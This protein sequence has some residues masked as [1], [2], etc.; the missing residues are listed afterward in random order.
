MLTCHEINEIKSLQEELRQNQLQLENTVDQ[1]TKELQEAL[2]VKSRFL[3]IM[4]HE[5]RTPLSGLI[6]RVKGHVMVLMC[7]RE[8]EFFGRYKSGYRTAGIA[9]YCSSVWRTAVVFD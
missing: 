2:Q 5:I 9:A 1:R 3:A 8:Y 7:D 6:G 4:S